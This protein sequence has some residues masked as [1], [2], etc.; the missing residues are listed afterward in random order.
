MVI[1]NTLFQ[2]ETAFTHGHP[3]M[4]NTEIKLIAFFF[5][6]K[7]GEAIYGQQKKTWS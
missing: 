3:Q 5:L 1:A 6:A 7:D 4:A 2:Q